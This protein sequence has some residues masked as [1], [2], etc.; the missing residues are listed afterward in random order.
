M[1]FRRP[2]EL[3]CKARRSLNRA[4]AGKHR[5]VFRSKNWGYVYGIENVYGKYALILSPLSFDSF[6]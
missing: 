6:R 1:A 4:T 3:N 5:E 2:S